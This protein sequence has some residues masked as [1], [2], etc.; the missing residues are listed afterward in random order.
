MLNK[1]QVVVNNNEET[2][3][4]MDTSG[5]KPP[6]GN[7]IMPRQ[8]ANANG[9]ATQKRLFKYYLQKLI[10]LVSTRNHRPTLEDT[11][12]ELIE[13]HDPE[14]AISE[15]ERTLVRN[16]LRFD[17]VLVGEVKIPRTDIIAIEDTASLK[18]VKQ[19]FI[20]SEHT[21][22][23]V[24]QENL[25]NISGFIHI[26]DLIPYLSKDKSFD[27]Q[28]I[29]R[30]TLFVPPSMKVI[31]LLAKMRISRVHIAIVLDEYGGTDGLVTMENLMEELVGD[32][33]DEHDNVDETELVAYDDHTLDASGRLEIEK[34]EQRL[35]IQF[36]KGE[37]DDD[38]ETVGG[39]I[40]SLAGYV[41]MKG[42]KIIH[43][44][45][46]IIFEVLEADPRKINRVKIHHSMLE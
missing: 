11:V 36:R 37:D 23:P 46:G 22:V 39:L 42:E 16:M 40:F 26:K 30:K 7:S 3:A 28:D 14:G 5:D 27:I 6:E 19:L 44:S 32:I 1:Q 35:G 17:D 20:E 25:D 18:E 15:E 9:E 29:V 10:A 2:E 31:D 4:S 43:E 41:P 12:V 21:R 34:L 8:S 13:E 24:Y 38:F 45:S 33:N